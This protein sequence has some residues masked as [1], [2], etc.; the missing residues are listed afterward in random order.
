LYVQCEAV[1]EPTKLFITIEKFT[2]DI[3]RK[4]M[5]S[6]TRYVTTKRHRSASPHLQ[7]EARHHFYPYNQKA[8]SII[9]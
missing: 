4:I 7:L 8:D 1:Q 3:R 2:I 9:W 5:I 6:P